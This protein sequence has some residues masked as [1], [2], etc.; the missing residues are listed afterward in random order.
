MIGA[1]TLGSGTSIWSHSTFHTTRGCS[2]RQRLRRGKSRER[3]KML[4]LDQARP[5]P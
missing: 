3:V 4:I 5:Y 2:P 1:P